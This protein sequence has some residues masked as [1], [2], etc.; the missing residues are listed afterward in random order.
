MKIL[1]VEKIREADRYTIENEPIESVD[2]MEDMVI[3]GIEHVMK[4]DP[5][6]FQLALQCF[7]IKA[8]ETTFIDDNVNNVAGANAMGITGI[9]FEGKEKLQQAIEKL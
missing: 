3:S 6:I 9:L 7:G 5:K 1:S 2:L 4:P 8:E